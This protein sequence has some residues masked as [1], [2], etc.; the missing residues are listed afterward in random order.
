MPVRRFSNNSQMMWIH[1][2]M[3]EL[4]QLKTP[5]VGFSSTLAG[6][7][8]C[9]GCCEPIGIAVLLHSLEMDSGSQKDCELWLMLIGFAPD[10]LVISRTPAGSS[11]S[12]RF[13]M[14][15]SC[16]FSTANGQSI[17]VGD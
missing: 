8:P 17:C 6:M 3:I 12:D 10:W 1:G 14:M 7:A 5:V 11:D 15:I 2:A 13:V 4:E 9:S 16:P